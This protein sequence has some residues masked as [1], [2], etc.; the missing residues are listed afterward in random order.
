MCLLPSPHAQQP[1]PV[2]TTSW[3]SVD[4]KRVS[5]QASLTAEGPSGNKIWDI[6]EAFSLPEGRINLNHNSCEGLWCFI[7]K[8]C[9]II[10]R[11]YVCVQA[12]IGQLEEFAFFNTS[13]CVFNINAAF[14]L[15]MMIQSCHPSTQEL[16]QGSFRSPELD[17]KSPPPRTNT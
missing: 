17:G 6:P 9:D 5:K 15:H 1:H 2:S 8:I 12:C 14:R 7:L 11:V 3:C 16:R 13:L 10:L 4:T